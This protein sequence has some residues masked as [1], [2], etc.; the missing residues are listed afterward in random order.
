MKVPEKCAAILCPIDG[1]PVCG[2]TG[3]LYNNFCLLDCA[4]DKLDEEGKCLKDNT[5]K[6][7]E[8]CKRVRCGT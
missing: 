5:P 8:Y 2:K 1:E 4:G 3:I 7:P 6:I